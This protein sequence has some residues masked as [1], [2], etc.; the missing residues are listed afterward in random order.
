MSSMSDSSCAAA[1]LVT[2]GCD[3]LISRIGFTSGRSLFPIIFSI[4]CICM[5]GSWSS[6]TMQDGES[7]RRWEARTSFTWSPSAFFTFCSSGSMAAALPVVRFR[8]Q[9]I[10]RRGAVD[11]LEVRFHE[12]ADGGGDDLVDLVVH[13]QDLQ[14]AR[15][16]RLQEGRV[17]QPRFLSPVM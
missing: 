6:T 13:D 10:R 15:L 16:V 9:V 1:S 12:L 11:R 4:C 17:A 3:G 2:M 7:A 14:A 5:V 8:L